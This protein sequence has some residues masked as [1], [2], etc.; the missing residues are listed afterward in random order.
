MQAE[1]GQAE[2]SGPVARRGR[3]GRR[4]SIFMVGTG[5][6]ALTLFGLWL[7]RAPIAEN[8]IERELAARDVRMTYHVAA[9]GP[10]TQRIENI[11]L[12]DPRNPDLTARWIE[13]DIGFGGLMPGVSEVR[14]GG[15]RLRGSYHGGKLSLGELDKFMGGGSSARTVLPDISIATSDARGSFVTDYGPLGLV[16]SG[17]GNVR[18]GFNGR[19]VASM[20]HVK[21]G[22]CGGGKVR[23]DL[24]I[25]M[26]G[27][28]PRIS[29]PMSAEAL[30]CPALGI[31]LASPRLDLVAQLDD[32]LALKSSDLRLAATAL[33]AS[34]MTLGKP[35]VDLD[36][37][38]ESGL[39]NGAGHLTAPVL[40]GRGVIAGASML[41]MRFQRVSLAGKPSGE[42][43]GR[44]TLA[45][46]TARGRDPLAGLGVAVA[47]TPLGPLADKLAKAVRDAGRDN[48]LAT[49]F[50]VNAQPGSGQARLSDFH[51]G[52]ASGAKVDLSPG[53]AFVLG[54]PGGRWNFSGDLAMGGGGLPQGRLNLKADRTGGVTGKLQMAPYASGKARLALAPVLFSAAPGGASRF[55]TVMTLDGPIAGGG[56][57][58]GLVLPLSGALGANGR[59]VLNPAC[60][61]V[62]WQAVKISSLALDRAAV[63][64]CPEGGAMVRSNGKGMAGGVRA[65]SLA[66]TGR[67]GSSPLVVKSSAFA[68]SLGNPAFTVRD[69]DVRIG[70]A[71]APVLLHAATLDGAST[72][73]M[74]AGRFAKGAARIGTVPFDISD[75]TGRWQFARGRLDVDSG[76]TLADTQKAARFHPLQA[77]AAH[78]TLADNRITAHGRLRHPTRGAE[79]VTVVIAHDL[80]SGRGTANFALDHLRF[81]PALQ[82]DDLTPTAL[83]VVANVQGFV[84]GGGEVVWTPQTVTSTG[85]F[86]T[87]DMKLAAAFGPVEGLSTTLNFTDLIAL[88]TAPHQVATIASVNP[89]IEARDGRITYQ[90]LRNQQARIEGGEW[91]FAGGRL[92]L[93][94]STLDFDA[95]RERHLAFRV[96]GL[97]AGAFIQTLD[98]KNISATGTYDGLL[99]IIFDAN[100]GRIEGGILVARQAGLPPLIVES[101]KTLSVACD[102][103]R[104]AGTLSYVGDVSNAELGTYGKMAF[105]ALK[106]LR[107]KCLTILLDGALDGE[108]VTQLGINGVNEGSDESRKSMIVRS[109]L[110]IP[111][112]FNIR[113][114]APFRG[115]LNTYQSF[116]D[117]STLI[118][119]SLGPQY[120]SVINNGVAVQPADSDKKLNREGE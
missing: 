107:Y 81:G 69:L 59:Y 20:P 113:I 117:P 77:R 86:S 29:G 50:A 99:P 80:G 40:H 7:A 61:P 63:S 21:L 36:I 118:R 31:A 68:A 1:E 91:P 108:F 53:G 89:G 110:G 106:H 38:H 96:T 52:A 4:A 120:Q 25:A 101:A 111:F 16:F 41:D 37:R 116:I 102:P 64:L 35:L 62:S 23:A 103:N 49:T 10:R 13:V 57:V 83:G 94:P 74:L 54:W 24:A 43:G 30:G 8:L 82:P 56:G 119:N 79:F 26:R 19:A 65:P 87:K 27:G 88:E 45:N 58:N 47:G 84:E 42:G 85:R 73:G 48:R 70:K 104:Q 28:A 71:D 6:A 90:L 60:V 93:L 72:K 46:I 51:F 39:Y 109:F 12:G 18:D 115:L 55:A 44:L 22:D 11:V 2:D 92:S 9:I 66:L 105:D 15:L 95:T 78:L 100:G 97:D 76:L 114:Q 17:A 5:V 112:I 33:R 34:G 14:A 3:F 67:I 98:L 32:T 75:I